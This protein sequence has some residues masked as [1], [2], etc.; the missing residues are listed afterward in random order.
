MK[1]RSSSAF[2]RRSTRPVDPPRPPKSEHLLLVRARYRRDDA[3][4]RERFALRVMRWPR[5]TSVRVET[6]PKH[7]ESTCRTRPDKCEIGPAPHASS[8][9]ELL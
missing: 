4:L 2:T 1:T 6:L 5:S 8:P 3:G 9:T 7:G